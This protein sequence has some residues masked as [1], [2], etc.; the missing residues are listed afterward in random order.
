MLR[1]PWDGERACA[2]RTSSLHVASSGAVT[3]ADAPVTVR[4]QNVRS[5]MVS[6]GGSAYA[7]PR[8]AAR[9]G[10]Q[11]AAA[12]HGV[13]ALSGLRSVRSPVGGPL[14]SDLS[15]DV[16]AKKVRRAPSMGSTSAD[17]ALILCGWNKCVDTFYKGWA[18]RAPPPAEL[19]SSWCYHL[20][21][22]F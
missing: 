15:A 5:L 19:P 10:G 8:R 4:T 20:V 14:A 1:T 7:G 12:L 21:L 2:S 13:G 6:V 3:S 9:A 11:L 22:E 17:P 16:G 18:P